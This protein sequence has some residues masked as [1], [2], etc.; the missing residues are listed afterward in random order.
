MAVF[1]CEYCFHMFSHVCHEQAGLVMAPGHHVELAELQ[2]CVGFAPG[3]V[4]IVIF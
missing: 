1:F 2:I 4:A 3:F